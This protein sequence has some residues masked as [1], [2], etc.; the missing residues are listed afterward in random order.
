MS[1]RIGFRTIG[2]R[3]H[4]AETAIRSLAQIGY[5]GVEVCL[6][7]PGLEPEEIDVLRGAALATV[8]A[9]ESIEIATVSYHGDRD[10][11]P[12]RWKRAL[13]AVELTS[14]MGAGTLIVNSPRPGPDAPEDLEEQFHEQLAMQLERAES[15]GVTLALEPEPGLL[16]ADV[17]DALDLIQQMGSEHLRVNLD[18]GHAFLTEDDVPAAIHRLGDLIV[19]AH[20]EDMPTGEHRHLVPGE[21]DMDL[22][23]VIDALDAVGFD[24]WLTVDLFD[25]ADAPDEAARASLSRM[26][27]L[28]SE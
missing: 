8:A 21:G 23:A 26:R 7:H 28:V 9:G 22:P 17:D 24:G 18:V 11:L 10:R 19:A 27:E 4:S 25:I 2:F 15:L 14:A 5:D 16:I 6:E 20:I 13:R 3:Q 1:K 12:T